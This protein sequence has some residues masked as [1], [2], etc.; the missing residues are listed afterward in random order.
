MFGEN[1]RFFTI[2][3]LFLLVWGC[4]GE[5]ANQLSGDSTDTENQP[6]DEEGCDGCTID[7]EWVPTGEAHPEELCGVCDPEMSSTDW[8]PRP[9]GTVCRE[10][11]FPCDAQDVCNGNELT[12]HD[13]TMADDGTPCDDGVECTEAVCDRGECKEVVGATSGCYIVGQCV[14]EGAFKGESSHDACKICSSSLSWNDW[15]PIDYGPCDDENPCTYSDSC[16]RGGSYYSSGYCQGTRY[17]CVGGNYCDGIGGCPCRDNYQDN[18]GDGLCEMA[19]THP[20]ACGGHYACDDSSGRAICQCTYR[21]PEL[22]QSFGGN[23]RDLAVVG[24]VAYVAMGFG[25]MQI[26]DVSD[27]ANPKMWGH[28]DAKG[29]I[30]VLDVTEEGIAYALDSSTLVIIDVNNPRHPVQI[31][32]YYTGG[33]VYDIIVQDQKAWLAMY[34]GFIVLDVSNPVDV[35]RI[36]SYELDGSCVKLQIAGQ[37]AYLQCERY[38]ATNPSSIHILD[39]SEPER[40]VEIASFKTRVLDDFHVEGQI[41]YLLEGIGHIVELDISDPNNP[42]EISTIPN[43]PFKFWIKDN[44]AYFKEY[45]LRIYDISQPSIPRLIGECESELTTMSNGLLGVDNILYN[46]SY[47]IEILESFDVSVPSD[48]KR[49]GGYGR[50][51]DTIQRFFASEQSI[52]TMNDHLL[53]RFDVSDPLNPKGFVS[54]YALNGNFFVLD[55]VGYLLGDEYVSMNR[56][57]VLD[58]SETSNATLIADYSFEAQSIYVSGKTLYSVIDNSSGEGVAI[59][60][61]SNPSHGYLLSSLPYDFKELDGGWMEYDIEVRGNRIFVGYGKYLNIFTFSEQFGIVHRTEITSSHLVKKVAVDALGQIVVVPYSE[62]ENKGLE[63]YNVT[64]IAQPELLS[65]LNGSSIPSMISISGNYIFALMYHAIDEG[66]GSREIEIIDI[67]NPAAPQRMGS[68]GLGSFNSTDNFRDYFVKGPYIYTGQGYK[69]LRIVKWADC[70][71]AE[72]YAGDRCDRCA[73]GYMNYPDCVPEIGTKSGEH[74]QARP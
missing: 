10:P 16:Q 61:F 44:L 21:E 59:Y 41:A 35:Q 47:D 66:S 45:S 63:I 65:R 70:P 18:D 38:D 64:D 26:L 33:T 36:S 15:T 49:L 20:D 31:G 7:G 55:D 8:S 5:G 29:V 25:G 50:S 72:G 9:K 6:A 58:M 22:I 34:D 74:P 46:I 56:L 2:L 11:A 62:D 42:T 73:E 24:N 19:C 32:S 71:C 27:P 23:A 14:K 57:Q 68:I 37:Y 43:H 17:H 54:W 30:D 12:C 4:S 28:F 40:I 39:I 51:P 1:V 53:V 48:P 13:D 60:D 67:S 52:Y 3:I 69:G